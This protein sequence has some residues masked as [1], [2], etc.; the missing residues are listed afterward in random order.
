MQDDTEESQRIVRFNAALLRMRRRLLHPVTLTIYIGSALIAA[1]AGPFGTYGTHNHFTQFILWLTLLGGATIA[2]YVTD[3]ICSTLYKREQSLWYFVI[4]IPAGGLAASLTLQGLLVFVFGRPKEVIPDVITLM[5]FVIVIM[6]IIIL[7]RR[8]MHGLQDMLIEPVTEQA[9]AQ[10][11][12]NKKSPCR[13]ARRLELPE[14]AKIIHISANGHFIDVRSY[15]GLHRVR[16][17]FSDAMLALDDG[18]GITTHRSHWVLRDAVKGWIRQG[19][20]GAVLLKDG[21]QV[22]I[23]K[24]YLSNVTDAGVPELKDED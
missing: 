22:P 9:K 24:T 10:P 5:F 1:F 2:I 20:K 18:D 15:D 17:R 7:A 19:T 8:F 4:Y 21:T 23:S 12:Q 14:G 3:V 6:G 16:M 11:Q 13:L